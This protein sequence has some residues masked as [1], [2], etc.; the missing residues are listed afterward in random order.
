MIIAVLIA[1]LVQSAAINS[2]RDNFISCLERATESA[3]AQKMTADALEPHLRAS[4][5]SVEESFK[6]ALIAFDVKNKIARKQAATDAKLQ[7]DDFVSSSVGQFK[8]A[9]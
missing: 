6:A 5:A 1:A 9:Q 2:Q 4:C 3:K 8:P 7:A